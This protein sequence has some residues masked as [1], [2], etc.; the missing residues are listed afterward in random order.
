MVILNVKII[1]ALVLT[2][3]P[4]AYAYF[5]RPRQDKPGRWHN[6]FSFVGSQIPSLRRMAVR[7]QKFWRRLQKGMRRSDSFRKLYT[8]LVLIILIVYQFVD[9]YA[10]SSLLD[11]AA[12]NCLSEAVENR[13]ENGVGNG[14][15]RGVDLIAAQTFLTQ[16]VATLSAAVLG[17]QLFFYKTADALL[18]YLH[19]S[20]RMFTFF[21]I[22]ILVILTTS[23]RLFI[24]AETMD[25]ILIAAF[26]YPEKDSTLPPR[27][28]K[29]IPV[30]E[31]RNNMKKTAA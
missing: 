4:F 24:L 23:P 21:S 16:P 2:A 22:A 8:L 6:A 18:T 11:T 12:N 17:L 7:A 9:F 25:I 19:V 3:I 5:V 15:G 10:A 27:K 13:V 14:V 1:L 31:N 30:Q 29:H 26:F 28:R 20:N